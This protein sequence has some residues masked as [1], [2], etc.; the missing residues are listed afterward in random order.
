M[1]K[2]LHKQIEIAKNN[3]Q[4]RIAKNRMNA[5][6][7]ALRSAVYEAFLMSDLTQRSQRT[8][9][10]LMTLVRAYGGIPVCELPEEVCVE[11]GSLR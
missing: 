9:R 10:R 7:G 2:K 6:T 11:I 3:E 4:L 5:R 1:N 8:G